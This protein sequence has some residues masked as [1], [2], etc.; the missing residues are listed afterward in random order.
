M[1]TAWLALVLALAP[2]CRQVFGLDPPTGTIADAAPPDALPLAD[3]GYRS[4]SRLKL[5]WNDYAGTREYTGIYDSTLATECQSLQWSDGNTYCTPTT[6]TFVAYLDA[7]CTMPVAQVRVFSGNCQPPAPQYAE[8]RD[9]ACSVSTVQRFFRV[10]DALAAQPFYEISS[11]VCTGPVTNPNYVLHA[12]PS[13]IS[14]ADLVQQTPMALPGGRLVQQVLAG[15]DGS[16]VRSTVRDTMLDVACTPNTTDGVCAPASDDSQF[17]DASCQMSLASGVVG[18]PSPEYAAQP[19]HPGCAMPGNHYYSVGAAS[20]SPTF[21]QLQYDGTCMSFPRVSGDNYFGLGA[22]VSTVPVTMRLGSGSGPIVRSYL[23]DGT[24]DVGPLGLYDTVHHTPCYTA[25]G[26]C[27]PSGGYVLTG[28]YANAT[29]TMAED[30]GTLTVG[31]AGCSVPPTPP[32]L[33]KAVTP[34]GACTA[35][36]SVETD[37]ATTT[38]DLHDGCELH[39]IESGRRPLHHDHGRGSDVRVCICDKWDGS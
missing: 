27:L 36:Y 21:Y 3:D 16:E 34:V 14:T 31:P 13:Q 20:L 23:N 11:G 26:Q 8:E 6:S 38:D 5:M 18:C 25:G 30:L 32:Y 33:V 9:V 29:C 17:F 19:Q 2:G 4:G 7:A 37:G 15:A 28:Y 10:G 22:E 39:R 12:L 24:S 35:M 1:R